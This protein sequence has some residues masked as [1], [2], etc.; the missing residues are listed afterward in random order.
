MHTHNLNTTEFL[1]AENSNLC[2]SSTLS[3]NTIWLAFLSG[4]RELSRRSGRSTV[5]PDAIACSNLRLVHQT[6]LSDIS[7]RNLLKNL[8]HNLDRGV[9]TKSIN[10]LDINGLCANLVCVQYGQMF[11][12]YTD[13]KLS[14]NLVIFGRINRESNNNSK[15]DYISSGTHST[16]KGLVL[17]TH[18]S[19]DILC[20]NDI[21]LL[22]PKKS[23]TGNLKANKKGAI[24]LSVTS[25]MLT[26]H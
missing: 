26:Q 15:T 18:Y 14:I 11:S 5:N 10:L 1:P 3:Q 7:Y 17:H 16:L 23:G 4:M 24:F 20:E 22:H 9:L 12:L 6:L 13:H 25:P 21:F 2:I 19:G 8:K